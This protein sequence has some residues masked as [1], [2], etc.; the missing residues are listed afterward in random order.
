MSRY[1]AAVQMA[2]KRDEMNKKQRSSDS[3]PIPQ[4]CHPKVR[5]IVEYWDSKRPAPDVLPG[6]QHLD[7]VDIP[8]LLSNVWLIDVTRD[9]LRFRFRLLGTAVVEYA[10]EDN[11]GKWFDEALPNFDPGVFIDV[12]ETHEPTWT[13]SASRM[14]P[15]K[16]YRELERVRMPLAR[17]GKT[18]DMILCLTVFFDKDGKEIK[19]G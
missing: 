19:K 17:D 6:R 11:T 5:Q 15:Y 2:V 18:V 7:P 12:V 10:G 4:A 1:H 16:E 14:R 13:R 3:L 8:D 9:P